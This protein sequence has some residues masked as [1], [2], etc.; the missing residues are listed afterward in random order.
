MFNVLNCICS[1]VW[2]FFSILLS[3]YNAWC[4]AGGGARRNF[5]V[6]SVLYLGRK[7]G[8]WNELF[9][10]VKSKEDCKW[11]W[12]ETAW[13]NWQRTYKD[14][15]TVMILRSSITEGMPDSVE[16]TAF[17]GTEYGKGWV[18]WIGVSGRMLI[19]WLEMWHVGRWSGA[20]S[21]ENSGERKSRSLLFCQGWL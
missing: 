5:C 15:K 17:F 14:R 2:H 19:C 8:K 18:A 13:W 16:Q 3:W 11:K 4:R 1:M 7:W 9:N 12:S 10:T 21:V 20:G 6:Q